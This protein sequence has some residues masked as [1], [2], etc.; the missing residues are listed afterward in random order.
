MKHDDVDPDDVQRGGVPILRNCQ[1]DHGSRY[2][3]YH[4]AMNSANTVEQWYQSLD[5]RTRQR[6][7]Y[8]RNL[9][10]TRRT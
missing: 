7:T 4:T 8:S 5:T 3:E 9:L 2:S 6:Q 1:G 10:W